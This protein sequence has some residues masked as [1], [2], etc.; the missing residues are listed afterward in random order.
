MPVIGWVQEQLGYLNRFDC[1]SL[2]THPGAAPSVAPG[3]GQALLN[4]EKELRPTAPPAICNIPEASLLTM[5]NIQIRSRAIVLLAAAL[6][7]DRPLFGQA[8][9]TTDMPPEIS[10][11]QDIE[12]RLVRFVI[13]GQEI[14]I[15]SN[16]TMTLTFQAKGQ[17]SGQSAVNRYGGVFTAMPNGKIVLKVTRATQMAG[18]PELMKLEKEYFDAL[19]NAK[20][21]LLKSDQVMLE[22][23]TTS[24]EFAFNR[25]R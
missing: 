2:F 18:P 23:E 19:S 5:T 1:S 20:Q 25:Q 4:P 13:R 16:I 11:Y 14:V 22:N 8:P 7:A 9:A 21:I 3:S 17:F 12:L 24:M 15:P 6:F 10:K